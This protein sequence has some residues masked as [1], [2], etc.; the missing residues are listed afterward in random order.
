MSHAVEL[1]VA[2]LGTKVALC[3]ALTCRS[4]RP[5]LSRSLR[6]AR[7]LRRIFETWHCTGPS[8]QSQSWAH[9]VQND[10]VPPPLHLLRRAGLQFLS[11]AAA[12][13]LASSAVTAWP[14]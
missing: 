13:A 9:T 10:A 1:L 7:R 5:A 6:N 12:A 4:G 2:A 8:K 11:A 14:A 3:D